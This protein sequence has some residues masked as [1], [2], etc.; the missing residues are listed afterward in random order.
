VSLTAGQAD[1]QAEVRVR[2]TGVGIPPE[3][4][5]RVF[6]LFTQVNRSLNRSQGGLG[7]GLALVRRLMEM[8]G[9]SVEVHSAGLGQ[10]AEFVVRLP[11]KSA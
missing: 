10:G 11:V 9:G 8:H 1:A 4:L 7:I 5:P 2:D 3:M 6:E